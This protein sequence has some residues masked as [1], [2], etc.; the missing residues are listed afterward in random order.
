MCTLYIRGQSQTD[1]GAKTE[2]A[3]IRENRDEGLLNDF[4]KSLRNGQKPKEQETL[5]NTN[6]EA[7]AKAGKDLGVMSMSTRWDSG[8]IVWRA[9]GQMQ[10]LKEGNDGVYVVDPN[11]KDCPVVLRYRDIMFAEHYKG[12]AI[13]VKSRVPRAALGAAIGGMPGAVW[14]GLGG[15]AGKGEWKLRIK[16]NGDGEDNIYSCRNQYD[17]KKMEKRISKHAHRRQPGEQQ[18]APRP[19]KRN[20]PPEPPAGYTG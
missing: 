9:D 3:N 17:A 20:V 18:P 13:G 12:S 2:F 16:E 4:V 15:G 19:S 14:L 10:V 8:I 7:D 6:H 1:A 5:S 11:Q